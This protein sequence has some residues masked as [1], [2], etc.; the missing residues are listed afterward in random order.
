MNRLKLNVCMLLLLAGTVLTACREQVAFHAYRSVS[1]DGWGRN[2]TLFF[3]VASADTVPVAVTVELQLRYALSY[4]YRN[5]SLLLGC[6]PDS[7][8]AFAPV[9]ADFTLMDADGEWKGEGSSVLRICTYE[10]GSTRLVQPGR[11]FYVLPLMADSC[12]TGISDVGLLV[13]RVE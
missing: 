12:L 8:P 6:M 13:K 4:P 5:L 3:E 11:R 10:A 7:M 2:D 1:D 9:T